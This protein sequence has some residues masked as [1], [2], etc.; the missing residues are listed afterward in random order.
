MLLIV[1]GLGL[2]GLDGLFSRRS[3][4][5]PT[6]FGRIADSTAD[7]VTFGAAPATL[8]VIHSYNPVLWNS[9]MSLAFGVA[10]FLFALTVARLVYFTM[11]GYQ[12]TYFVGAPTPQTALAV[13]VLVLFFQQ[14]AFFGTN[15]PLLLAG[16]AIAAVCMVLPI[17][18]PK[19]RRG[20]PIRPLSA[21]TATALV[22]AL[23]PLQFQPAPS[24]VA[25]L[26]SLAL[27]VVGGAGVLAY[28]LW[29][30]FTVEVE[31]A[32]PEAT[33]A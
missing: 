30:P 29:G 21:L 5:P 11:H 16:V 22:L 27:A 28:Y 23:L 14:P 12:R 1:G 8:I 26:F 31:P 33:G 32:K 25:Y 18:Y 20:A 24:S 10:I 7:A 2:D 17:P 15:P 3:H 13:V 19:V 6:T 9:Y 4:E